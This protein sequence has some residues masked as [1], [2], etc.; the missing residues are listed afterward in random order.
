MEIQQTSCGSLLLLPFA[1][2][3]EQQEIPFDL[4]RIVP[5]E[6]KTSEAI[7]RNTST[8]IKLVFRGHEMRGMPL[9]LPPNYVAV[10][11]SGSG[12]TTIHDSCTMFLEPGDHPQLSPHSIMDLYQMML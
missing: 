8:P 3:T 10:L 7:A 2:E 11:H 9:E 4:S 5:S 12:A 1:L 6:M